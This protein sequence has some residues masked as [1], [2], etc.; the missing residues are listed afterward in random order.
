MAWSNQKTV[1]AAGAGIALVVGVGL[2][3]LFV[4]RTLHAFDSSPAARPRAACR[5]RSIALLA[6]QLEEAA[7]SSVNDAPVGE[8]S[9]AECARQNG[10]L[11]GALDVGLDDNGNLPP[12]PRPRWP[13]RRP[14]RPPRALP[15][16]AQTAV[17]RRRAGGA[18]RPGRE[19]AF[20]RAGPD[21]RERRGGVSTVLQWRMAPGVRLHGIERL[22]PG[23][24]RR[25]L[26]ASG[27][28]RLWPL[29]RHP[30][31]RLVPGQ[32]QQAT[33]NVHFRIAVEQRRGNCE[34]LTA[35]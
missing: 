26:P 9:L 24:V 30:P 35:H 20:S 7:L 12:R 10:V 29:R 18:P 23:A 25:P 14:C 6:E 28:G 11:E 22:R 19:P 13:R 8:L 2:R 27:R 17:S 15:P 31:L 4:A 34:T 32:V 3:N 1:L 33:D 21:A 5:S 16:A